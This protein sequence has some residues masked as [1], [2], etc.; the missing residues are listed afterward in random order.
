MSDEGTAPARAHWET[1][2]F[3]GGYPLCPSTDHVSTRAAYQ[4]ALYGRATLVDARPRHTRQDGEMGAQLEPCDVTSIDQFSGPIIVVGRT[5]A[6]GEVVAAALV[7]KGIGS[8]SVLTGGFI[9]WA[10]EG[11]PV[12]HVATPARHTHALSA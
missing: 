10:S 9:A 1:T 2:L 6:E 12:T 8:V 4:D 11:F 5:C 7:R 3:S